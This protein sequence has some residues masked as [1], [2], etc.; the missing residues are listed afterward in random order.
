MTKTM[1]RGH[2]LQLVLA[3]FACLAGEAGK[4]ISNILNQDPSGF[5][6][7]PLNGSVL[8]VLGGGPTVL[9]DRQRESQVIFSCHDF[10]H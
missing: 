4:G 10:G 2:L 5:P 6:H 7:S 3:V 1:A 8:L 9:L